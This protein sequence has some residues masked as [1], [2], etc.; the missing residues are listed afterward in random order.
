MP[1]SIGMPKS[2]GDIVSD[3]RRADRRE[4]SRVG[5]A[6]P[7]ATI[8]G[9]SIVRTTT[10]FTVALAAAAVVAAAHG[11]TRAQAPLP[12]GP[13]GWEATHHY[14]QQL[15]AD[16]SRPA[17]L[18]I[19]GLAASKRAFIDPRSQWAVSVVPYDPKGKGAP[20]ASIDSAFELALSPRPPGDALYGTLSTA[21]MS[22]ATWNQS[23][24]IPSA[25]GAAPADSC[26]NEDVFAKAYESARWAL[27]KLASQTK[28]PIA[29]VGHGRGG[30]ILRRLL[31]DHGNLKGRIK[32]AITLHTPH[33][34]TA[35][36]Q[37]PEGH[38]N[39]LTGGISRVI[40]DSW[41]ARVSSALGRFRTTL[42]KIA[43]LQGARELAA[44]A[45]P[46][47]VR[48][49]EEPT[50]GVRYGT[51]GGTSTHV[52]G[53]F[54]SI[55]T[56]SKT[57]SGSQVFFNNAQHAATTHGQGDTVVT[58]ASAQL[59]PTPSS[60]FTHAVHH[61][62]VLWHAPAL[63]KV[64]DIIEG[65]IAVTPIPEPPTSPI[66]QTGGTLLWYGHGARAPEVMRNKRVSG[67][68]TIGTGWHAFSH[69]FGG[70]AGIIY[71]VTTSGDLVWHRDASRRGRASWGDGPKKIGA[72]FNAY[73][74]VFGGADGVIY[75]RGKYNGDLFWFNDS[76]RDGTGAVAGPKKIAE[77]FG[78][79]THLTGGE[80]GVIYALKTNGDLYCYRDL[81]R[82]GASKWLKGYMTP[83]ADDF[84]QL[85]G[86]AGG[87]IYTVSAKGRMRAYTHL[88]RSTCKSGWASEGGTRV[89]RSG[90]KAK[91]WFGG[92]AGRLYAITK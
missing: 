52:L 38:Y 51:F 55:W 84:E 31:K 43:R 46:A 19:H 90:A 60:H 86:G 76:A 11:S 64:R 57:S 7:T 27:K 75:A 74:R 82:A 91:Y 6:D 25:A 78:D 44:N 88:H 80:D 20:T 71:G 4:V 34:G 73:D 48:R 67:G 35:I 5:A 23:P 42:L 72:G 50:P 37:N 30:L 24:C 26:L 29:L 2:A 40:P 61:R 92:P 32:W 83:P 70:H 63:A 10:G 56:L 1:T 13:P 45:V 12:S 85:F 81:S 16:L 79:F 66:S 69:V 14:E 87:W 49:G 65:A 54:W 17:V 21:R 15:T 41:A 28:G 22:V 39:A 62:E 3:H 58:N 89:M 9:R 8:E 53:A 33:Q 18:M 36:G 47:Q 77:G 68:K 59:A